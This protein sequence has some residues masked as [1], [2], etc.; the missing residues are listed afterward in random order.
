[1]P[2]VVDE[3]VHFREPGLTHKATIL[4]ESRA[5]A[6]GGVTTYFDMPNT[7]PQTTTRDAWQE[8]VEIAERDSL[9]NYAFFFGATSHNVEQCAAL[10]RSLFPGIK[11]FMGASTGN[12]L[13]SDEAVLDE[14]FSSSRLPIMV[15]AEDTDIVNRNMRLFQERYGDD[16]PVKCHPLIRSREACLRST[17]KAVSFCLKHGARLHVAHV[18]TKE[19]IDLLSPFASEGNITMEATVAHLLFSEDDYLRLG[20]RIK[21][22]PAVKSQ[23]DRDALR[24]AVGQGLVAAIGTDHAPHL[25]QE[26]EGGA[27]LAL[28]GMP[29]VQFSLVAMLSLVEQGVLT[30]E[31]LVQMMCH[32]PARLFG[33]Q[34]R[35]AIQ[36]GWYGDIVV[37]KPQRWT[38]QKA[39]IESLCKWSP[40]EG[41]EFGNKVWHVFCNGEHI[42]SEACLTGRRLAKQCLFA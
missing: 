16:P 33:L 21:C 39:D 4:S 28:S 12:M 20:A 14:L 10:D 25:V 13:V 35:G 36:R 5:A 6:L 29:M 24:R 3:H 11:L 22:N 7:K 26:K 38:L 9:V 19:E 41:M 42:V 18:S 23:A 2:G 1:M 17:Q 8:K 34:E 31:Q 37:V 32:G 40:L 27:R 30:V 15:H